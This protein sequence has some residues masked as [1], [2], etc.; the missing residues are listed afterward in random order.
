MN[1][2]IIATDDFLKSVKK[3][4]KKHKSII[5]D[6]ENLEQLLSENPTFG[7]SLGN[8]LFKIR[9]AISSSGKG[10]S[11]GSRIITYVKL[12]DSIVYMAE[13]Y[14]KSEISNVDEKNILQRLADDKLI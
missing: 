10:K 8:N 1:F 4:Y 12:I 13:I 2:E 6:L 5:D 9:L 14:L 11:G 7:T 3:I